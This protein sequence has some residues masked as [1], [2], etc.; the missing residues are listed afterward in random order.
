MNFKTTNQKVD[1]LR[2]NTIAGLPF[3]FPVAALWG[4]AQ[5]VDYQETAHMVLKKLN[6]SIIY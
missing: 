5:D 1:I 2:R 4:E 6:A 3:V